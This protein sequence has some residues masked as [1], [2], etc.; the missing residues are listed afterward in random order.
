MKVTH[1]TRRLLSPFLSSLSG[2][3]GLEI[4]GN[5]TSISQQTSVIVVCPFTLFSNAFATLSCPSVTRGMLRA[6]EAN[7]EIG[8][9]N[10]D[11]LVRVNKTFVTNSRS[12]K[13]NSTH[14]CNLRVS[15]AFETKA[16]QEDIYFP[17]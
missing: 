14:W 7:G 1:D 15:N 13:C 17:C 11:G 6:N 3:T 12:G 16:Y 4:S 9:I 10:A 8:S 2:L 5:C